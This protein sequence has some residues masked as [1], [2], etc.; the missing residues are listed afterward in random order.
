MRLA[1]NAGAKRDLSTVA[2]LTGALGMIGVVLVL[3]ACG[4]GAQKH[5]TQKS[6]APKH[7]KVISGPIDIGGRSL[8]LKCAGSGRPVVVMDA[9]MGTGTEAWDAVVPAIS[10]LTRTCRHDRAGEGAS[11]SVPGPRTAHDLVSDLRLL[12]ARAGVAPPYVLVGWSF[13]GL[14]MRLFAGEYPREVVG[15]VLVDASPTTL[16]DGACSI[17]TALCS[18]YRSA[19][20]SNPEGVQFERSAHE[21]AA[22]R[23]PK[24]P[25]IVISASSHQEPGL[26]GRVNRRLEAQWQRAQKRVAASVPGGRLEVLK[27]FHN[28]PQAHPRA[29]T[30]VVGEVLKK[31]RLRSGA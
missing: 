7:D 14:D 12:L 19:W 8:Y 13:G 11:D 26:G 16:I 3:A 31:A 22:T 24:I 30:A 23:L 29:V 20:A 28:I 21:V 2:F 6:S 5:D 15:L 9:G 4:S 17:S 25:L 27:G 1:R 18:S 10:K